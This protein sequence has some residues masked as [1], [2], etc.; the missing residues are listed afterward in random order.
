[1]KLPAPTA[2]ISMSMVS[3]HTV[4]WD[5]DGVSVDSGELHCQSWLETLTTPAIPFNQT[6]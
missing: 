4:L 5:M 3:K 1:M 6:R 2:A